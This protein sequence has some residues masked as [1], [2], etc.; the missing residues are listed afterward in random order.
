MP[1]IVETT[2][3]PSS[4]GCD[5][6][7]GMKKT[8]PVVVFRTYSPGASKAS[9][10]PSNQYLAPP[11]MPPTGSLRNHGQSVRVDLPNLG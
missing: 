11:V 2:T 7:G 8:I 5:E 3:S 4:S 10:D 1:S 9:R 6:M